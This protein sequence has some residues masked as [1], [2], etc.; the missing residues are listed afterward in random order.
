MREYTH[1]TGAILLFLTFAYL[2]NYNN[3]IIGIFIA[4]WISVF[5]DIIDKLTG[6]HRGIGHSILWLIPF[7][8]L[9]IFNL[10]I[11]I[12]MIIGFISHILLDL[13]TI[14]G[15]PVLYPIIKTD[16]VCFN[17][18]KRIKTG[19]YQEKAA[20]VFL[21]FLLIPVLFFITNIG[22]LGGHSAD[23]NVVFASNIDTTNSSKNNDT[24]KNNYNLNFELNEGTNKKITVQK[25]SENETTIIINDI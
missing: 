3:L 9:G 20:F 21:L 23:Q 5:P 13:M 19:T 18:R 22:S 24:I 15:C 6:K 16:F 12:A 1:I 2:T 11:A 25:V 10:T 14:H 7:A 8:L 4:G 17:R